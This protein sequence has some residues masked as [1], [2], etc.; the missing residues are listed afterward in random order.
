LA[1]G[2]T[3]AAADLGLT[4]DPSPTVR[5]IALR[6]TATID[7]DGL[8][9]LVSTTLSLPLPVGLDQWATEARIDGG[10]WFAYPANGLIP[11]DP[12]PPSG[13]CAVEIL[14]LVEVGA[15]GSLTTEAQLIDG[16]S[17]LAEA[18]A[19]TNIL[20]SVDAGADLLVAQ[21]ASVTLSGA[22]AGDGG[23]GIATYAWSDGG[24]GGTFDDP[25]ILHPTYTSAL[26]S[27]LVELALTVTDLDG[28]TASDSLRLRVNAP[29]TVDAGADLAC[30]E[31][32][33]VELSDAMATD[34]DGWIATYAWSD[35]GVGGAFEPSAAVLNPTYVP[36]A[37]TGDADIAID[38]TLMAADDRGG[39]GSDT[40]VLVV[41]N[42]NG[43][44]TVDA[45][46]DLACDEGGSVELS[47]ATA[48]D[49][50]GWIAAYD[51]SDGGVGGTFEPSTTTPNP[52][53]RPAAAA[54]CGAAAVL[55]SLTVTDN[56][57]LQ[58]S[59]DL[60]LTVRNAN[61]VPTIDVGSDRAVDV[62]ET[63]VLTADAR[64]SDGPIDSVRWEQTAGPAVVL[65]PNAWSE[66]V[67]FE[68]PDV[69]A[70]TVMAFRATATDRCGA[71]ASDEIAIEVSPAT[72]EGPRPRATL[73]VRIEAVG[74]D[75]FPLLTFDQVAPGE[76]IAFRVAVTNTGEAPITVLGAATDGGLIVD[77]GADELEPW[78]STSGWIRLSVD[79]SGPGGAYH[80][81]IT[82]VGTDPDGNV[83]SASDTFVL[84]VGADDASLAVWATAD[85]SEARVGERFMM[86]YTILNVGTA[87]LVGVGLIDDRLGPIDLPASEL[88]PG[89]ELIATAERVV[90]SADLPGP[91]VHHVTASG[92][93]RQAERVEAQATVSIDLLADGEDV[94]GGGASTSAAFAG[95]V[96]SEIAWAGTAT[97]PTAEWIELAN[98]G[99]GPVDL[100]GWRV[101]WYEKGAT[102]PDRGAWSCIELAGVIAPM[103]SAVVDGAVRFVED[104]NGVWQVVDDRWDGGGVGIFLLER[105]NDAVVSDVAADL[106]YDEDL[107]LPDTGAVVFLFDPDGRI[108][109]SAN[110]QYPNRT[111]WPGGGGGSAATMERRRLDLGD[112][113]SNWQ[114]HAGILLNGRDARGRP[115]FATAGRPNGPSI[116]GLIRA[117]EGHVPGVPASGTATVPL[118]TAG[119]SPIIRVAAPSGTT[120]AGGGG[121][122]AASPGISSR[123]RGSE[124]WLD[125]DLSGV[126]A[127]T[128]YVWIAYPDGRAYLLPLTK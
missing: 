103:P 47:D 77:L 80:L 81:T 69:A 44:P 53:Y 75:G 48:T 38:L 72:G 100:T 36:P 86:T 114:T 124:S 112:H 34:A 101:C 9:P 18:S 11:L 7:H 41:R 43:P 84:Y 126:P 94:A 3:A 14:T 30:N 5:G 55:L 20:P 95:P 25:G 54:G 42:V 13:Q 10:A 89:E 64:D 119:A 109:D 90:R 88:A 104:E 28:G 123:R 67:R 39:T 6:I 97:D 59:D 29:P 83:V 32:E 120:V 61:A 2:L 58:A 66:T 22:S 70:S 60:V 108:A 106:V 31:G 105:G 102:I 78:E 82:V 17:I 71:T 128:Y 26:P 92:F 57:G 110:A 51:W 50:D 74:E 73:E 127:G 79:A 117:A 16:F 12:I 62:G 87:S 85:R 45:G 68:P 35:G 40:L 1:A 121:S 24:A 37:I 23:A 33:S 4:I 19:W 125:V 98:P 93:T 111:G 99:T 15:P 107:E 8:T 122:A 65:E 113:D 76:E 116:D 63:V 27:G 118:P 56:G 52:T 91:S 49:A 46:P 21:G 96:L 115:L